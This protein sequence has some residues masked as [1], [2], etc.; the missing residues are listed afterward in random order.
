MTHDFQFPACLSEG[1][2]DKLMVNVWKVDGRRVDHDLSQRKALKW[3]PHHENSDCLGP[4]TGSQHPLACWVNWVSQFLGC[5]T[6]AKP[7]WVMRGLNVQI[8]SICI[9]M[10]C[11][12]AVTI[13]TTIPSIG[14]SASVIIVHHSTFTFNHNYHLSYMRS[15]PTFDQSQGVL[16][17]WSWHDLCQGVQD[18]PSINPLL[19]SKSMQ[20]IN[21]WHFSP[22]NCDCYWSYPPF[23]GRL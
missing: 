11:S 22:G 6:H 14:Y 8:E 12:T 19:H 17:L 21:K 2:D 20:W 1:Y 18:D 7:L 13:I 9:C 3:Y 10:W 15:Y 16:F 4:F 23:V 5:W